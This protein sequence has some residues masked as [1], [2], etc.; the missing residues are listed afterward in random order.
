MNSLISNDKVRIL[1][2]QFDNLSMSELLSACCKGILVT[3]NVDHIVMLQRD[4][5]FYSIYR[6]AD[7]V[8]C[9]SMI[10][11]KILKIIG[12]PLKGVLAGSDFFPAFYR[13]HKNNPKVTIFL[14]GSK[15]NIATIAMH[16]INEKVGRKIVVGSYSPSMGFEKNPE[17]NKKI[18]TLIRTSGANVLVVGVGA[19]KQ[20]KWIET[21]KNDLPEIDLFLPLGATI[22]FEAEVVKR[23]PP[24]IRKVGLEWLFRLFQDPGRLMKR[25]LCN[26]IVF[27]W[28]M[29]KMIMG[30]YKD[31]F[32]KL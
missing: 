26:D 27:F 13:H 14:L 8:V 2:I 4:F 21:Y 32:S 5:V 11:F 7:F 20:E 15:N 19:P 31:P 1:N 25:Y 18:I 16:K 17:E 24:W 10:V 3:P 22:D 9:D 23:A 29:L 30:I 12:I 6:N 28:L